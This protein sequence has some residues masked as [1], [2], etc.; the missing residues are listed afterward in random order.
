MALLISFSS[1]VFFL[2]LPELL[3][4]I[5]AEDYR[6]ANALCTPLPYLSCT[7]VSDGHRRVA[8][9]YR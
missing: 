4:K 6:S 8:M 3:L 1:P 7:F 2:R 5:T 9:I